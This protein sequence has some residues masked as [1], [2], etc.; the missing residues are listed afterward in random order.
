MFKRSSILVASALILGGVTCGHLA[1]RTPFPIIDVRFGSEVPYNADRETGQ[2]P[3][4]NELVMVFVG[5]PT[6]GASTDPAVARLVR[7]AADH[8]RARSVGEDARMV[9][10]GVSLNWVPGEGW[11]YLS[12]I[13]N[14]DE[15]VIGRSWVNSELIELVWEYP[16]AIAATPQIIV[17]RQNVTPPSDTV[18][19]SLRRETPTVWATGPNGIRD[20]AEAGYPLSWRNALAGS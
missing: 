18:R 2:K 11:R 3:E 10:V 14:F 4:G 20:W 8:L 19:A 1:K 7:E 5:S 6:C 15:V 12:R 13:M 17:F 16:H 9:S